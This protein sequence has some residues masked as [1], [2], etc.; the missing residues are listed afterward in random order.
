[1][2]FNR[3]WQ[4]FQKEVDRKDE[5]IDLLHA[6]LF[7]AQT[8][9]PDLNIDTYTQILD[10][11]ADSIV[12]KL[13][14]TRYP[15]KVIKTINDYLFNELGFYGNTE[16]YYNPKNSYINEVLERRTGIPISLSVVYLEIAKRI[17][18]PMV[19]IGM[20]GHFLI[21]PE[22]ED[23]GFFVDVFYSGEIIFKSDCEDRLSQIY[24]QPMKLESR[25]IEPVTTRQILARMLTNLKYIYI[26][27]RELIKALG[28]AD[29]IVMLYPD[30]PKEIRDRGLLHYQL[31]EWQQAIID[32]NFYL[33]MCPEAEDSDKVRS[34]LQRID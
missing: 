16:D 17:D 7:L 25:F 10:R 22:L 27:I 29:G 3:G 11:I 13:P 9:Y 2:N 28:V 30:N 34:L 33:K 12:R 8:E 21:C 5:D 19:G 18:F 1:M 4:N 15:L 23:V 26:N 31:E 24:Q 14:E 20:P 32:L 6:A